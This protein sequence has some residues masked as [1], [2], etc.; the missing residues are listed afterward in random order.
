MVG[1]TDRQMNTQ[2][3]IDVLVC[4]YNDNEFERKRAEATLE[5]ARHAP[6]VPMSLLQICTI[7]EAPRDVRQS[8]ALALKMAVKRHWEVDTTSSWREAGQP[9]NPTM[10]DADK[11][12]LRSQMLEVICRERDT[13]IAEILIESIGT[14]VNFDFPEKW[15]NLLDMVLAKLQTLEPLAVLNSLKVLR[16]MVKKFEYKR[17]EDGREPLNVMV[18]RTFPVLLELMN[19]LLTLDN[20]EAANVLH[21]ILKVYWSCTQYSV[22]NVAQEPQTVT[23]WMETM[24]KLLMKDIPD[25]ALP[26]EAEDRAQNG[27]WKA[28][29]WACHIFARFFS[30]FGIVKFADGDHK[31][32]AK[33]F[34]QN[35][36]PLLLQSC[37]HQLQ[38]PKQGRYCSPRVTHLCLN[39]VEKSIELPNTWA[40]MKPHLN[41][42]LFECVFPLL[43]MTEDDMQMFH[44]D[45]HEFVRKQH[46]IMEDFISPSM[47]GQSLVRAFAQ[48]KPKT[49]LQK[50]LDFMTNILNTYL[51]LSPEHKAQQ[52]P[53]KDGALKCIGVLHESLLAHKK[54]SAKLEPMMKQYVFPE[55]D[56][57]LPYLRMRAA[58]MCKIYSGVSYEPESQVILVTKLMC[59]LKDPTLPVQIQVMWCV[60]LKGGGGG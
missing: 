48:Y 40:A 42:I 32:F 33:F 17:Q 37:L 39:Y 43:C 57:P 45:P 5:Q 7:P 10:C 20:E 56:S 36:A 47:A 29:K 21:W 54:W 31:E 24:N 27:W 15:G 44:E 3:I 53:K 12:A 2:Q 19:N 51:R 38:L 34:G 58:W 50:M 8:A 16:K 11:N 25:Q 30:R 55:F 9:P 4:T 49:T 1:K 41:F 22:P 60:L 52:G 18:G 14:M 59:S 35:I 46:D 23:S 6:G 26:A 28:K 13:S